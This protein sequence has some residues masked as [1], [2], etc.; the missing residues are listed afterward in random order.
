M[1]IWVMRHGEAGFNAATDSARTLTEKGQT[2][3]FKQGQWLSKRLKNQN[4]SLDKVI[5]SPYVRTQQTADFVQ[6]GMQAVG[7]VQ[8]FANIRESW[9]GITPD[10]EPDN[11]LNYLDFLAQNGVENVL[12]VSHLPL[13]FDLVQ[14]LTQHQQSVHFYPAVITEVEWQNG[15]GNLVVSEFPA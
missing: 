3:A 4:V 14:R 10:G 12:L 11:V 7:C 5:V 2:M 13:V 8:S 1:K 9:A 6:Q 15:V